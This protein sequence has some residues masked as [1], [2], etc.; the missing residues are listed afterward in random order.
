MQ[1]TINLNLLQINCS[2]I[3]LYYIVIMDT[4]Y[5]NIKKPLF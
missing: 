3:S 1:F 2:V 5:I 4:Q